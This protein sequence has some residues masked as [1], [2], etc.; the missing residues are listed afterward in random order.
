[1]DLRT[2]KPVPGVAL[3]VFRGS[4]APTRATTDARG[5][6]DLRLS[7]AAGENAELIARKGRSIAFSRFYPF[8]WDA[9]GRKRYR[10]LPYTDRPV[11][12]PGH[13]VRFK[14]VVR[15]LEGVGYS[16]P[17]SR[18]LDV[19][20]RDGQDTVLFEGDA[21]MNERGS[22]AGELSL[23]REAQGGSY[24]LSVK[25]DGEEHTDTF[26]VASYRK[27]E[28]RVDVETPRKSYVRG[29]RV[30]VMVRATYYYGAPVV[31]GKVRYTVYRSRYWAWAGEDEELAPDEGEGESGAYGEVVETGEA[32]TDK[33]GVARFEFGAT[34]APDEEWSEG[35]EYSVEA[36]VADMS[37]RIATGKGSVRVLAGELS[38]DSRPARTVAA[39]GESVAVTTAAKDLEGNP[40]AGVSLT[41]TA[42]LDLW[43]GGRSEERVLSTQTVTTDAQGK[44]ELPVQLPEAGLVTVKVAGSDRRGNR[45]DSSASIWVSTADGGDLE[46][47]YPALSVIPDKKRYAIGETASVLVNTDKPGATAIVA[48]EAEEV[49][50]YQLVP[51]KSKSTVVR[52]PIRAGYEPNVFVT[53][54]FVRGR[55]FAS[56]SAAL[57]VNA[58]VHRLKVE[59]ESDR[60]VYQPGETA[61]YRIR[62]TDRS[63]RG[64]PAE[65][66]FG[67]VDEAVY[68]IRPEPGRGLWETFYPRRRNEV[69]TEFSYPEI[70]LGDADKDGGAVPVRKEFP[71]TAHWSAFVVTD[72]SGRATVQVTLP[73]SL[74]SWRAT[75]VGHTARTEVGRATHN[76]RVAKELTL[77]L[78]SPRSAT[79]GDRLTLSAVAHNYSAG[80]LE[81]VVDLKAAGLSVQGDTRRPV[82]LA[83]GAAE[84]VTWDVTASTPGS[85][86]L[87]ATAVAG[88]LS[89][90][91]QLTLPVRAFA[92]QSVH[93][94]TGAVTA[95]AATEKFDIDPAAVS[96]EL[97][98]RLAPTLAGSLLGAMEYLATYPHGCTEQ[99]MSSFMPNLVLM[100]T[101]S[102]LGLQ[103]PELQN[104]LPEMTQ[105]GLL[106]LYR[107]QH[108]DGGWGWW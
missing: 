105:A 83:A 20:V 86:T 96:V 76:I 91:M 53:A 52:F 7:G 36:E 19:E 55:E 71:D 61:V 11:Y 27:P 95:D 12:R 81:V 51:L 77:R 37:D 4:T 39:P 8:G 80:P 67:V 28:W 47:R 13:K 6:A 42:S 32:A 72:R 103:R 73:D 101:L 82:R 18:S 93:Y 58:E 84:R 14:G 92:R 40:A 90:G 74:T 23:P 64:V 69:A 100:R 94:G 75:A 88:A 9:S 34:A 108:P 22:F 102:G 29:E 41:V 85:A 78:Q 59:I 68:A 89:D 44:A 49:L 2:G 63:G 45:I 62:T 99:T 104:R 17:S 10:M 60:E 3:S 21:T 48:L 46:T 24:T 5:I 26:A 70:Y 98:L 107:Y 25:I 50:T 56:S 65:V 54:C 31:E 87:S 35:Y 1:A 57:S 79:E 106:R 30:P 38:L 97:E 43:T 33:D 66:S 15:R 16:V